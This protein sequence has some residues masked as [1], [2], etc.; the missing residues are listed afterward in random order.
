MKPLT[1]Q[2]KGHG[3]TV[4]QTFIYRGLTLNHVVKN[5]SMCV[6]QFSSDNRHLKHYHYFI[7][8]E[9]GLERIKSHLSVWYTKTTFLITTL[10]CFTLPRI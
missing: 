4:T 9:T 2:A 6:F 1:G 5:A 10:E 7:V 3:D 8:E